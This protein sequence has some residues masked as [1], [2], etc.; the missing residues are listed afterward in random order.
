MCTLSKVKVD[1][2]FGLLDICCVFVRIVLQDELFQKQECS[3][4]LYFL[5]N[6]HRSLPSILCCQSSTFIALLVWNNILYFKYLLQDG[7]CKDLGLLIKTICKHFLF[8][9]FKHFFSFVVTS[10]WIVNL[11]LILLLWGSVQM[12]PASTRRTLLR[13]LSFFK[14]SVRSSRDSSAA[15]IQIP[16]GWR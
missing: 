2:V 12:N 15:V 11:T 5:S 7:A 13:P 9:S 8:F 4:V 6:L 1:T 14:H 10:F 3:L 16:G